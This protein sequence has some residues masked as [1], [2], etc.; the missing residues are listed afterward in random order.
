[1][2]KS[3]KIMAAILMA[4]IVGSFFMTSSRNSIISEN[5]NALSESHQVKR[6][7]VYW[8]VGGTQNGWAKTASTGECQWRKDLYADDNDLQC[9]Y[10]ETVDDAL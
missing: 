5:V 3:K 1:M 4:I 8:L 2:K 7:R 10:W 6:W 9:W